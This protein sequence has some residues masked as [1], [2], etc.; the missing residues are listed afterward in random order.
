MRRLLL[1]GLVAGL[2]VAL[3]ALLVFGVLQTSDDSSLDQAIARGEHPAAPDRALPLLDGAGT[4]RLADHRGK[5]VVVNFF[6]SWCD[7]CEVEAPVLDR[8]Q[9]RLGHEGTVVGVA[10]NDATAD[11]RE[12]VRDFGIS[13]PIVRD[14]GEELGEDYEL[15]GLPESFVVDPQ[16]RI[17]AIAR[18]PIDARWVRE[19]LEPLLAGGVRAG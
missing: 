4:M 15:R 17:A 7:P 18:G 6:A 9:R 5:W 11:T 1:P 16:G 2:A 13:F 3:L 14:V 8:V 19:T 12:F 10:W